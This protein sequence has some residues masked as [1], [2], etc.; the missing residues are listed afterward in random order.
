MRDITPKFFGALALAAGGV[1][2]H[3]LWMQ[4]FHA[5]GTASASPWLAVW[6]GQ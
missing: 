5:A 2:A 6:I 4:L 3:G 1:M